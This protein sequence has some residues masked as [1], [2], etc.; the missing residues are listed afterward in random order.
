MRQYLTQLKSSTSS[1]GLGGTTTQPFFISKPLMLMF[2]QAGSVI[3]HIHPRPTDD[4][5]DY[6]LLI[7][8]LARHVARAFDVDEKAVWGWMD[9][10]RRNPTAEI[11]GKRTAG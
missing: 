4:Y 7:C 2:E 1:P 11:E 10:E 6:A 9:M 8:D 5:R 3:C